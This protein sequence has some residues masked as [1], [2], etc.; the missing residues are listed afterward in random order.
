MQTHKNRWLSYKTSIFTRMSQLSLDHQAINLSQG[1]PN[2]DGPQSIKEAA[3]KAIKDGLNQYAPSPGVLELREKIAEYR[4]S[5]SR[6]SYNPQDEVTVFSGATEALWAALLGLCEHGDEVISFAPFYDSYRPAIEAAGAKLK[7]VC[8]KAPNFSFDPDELKKQIT[9][10]TKMIILNHPHNPTGRVFTHRELEIIADLA[11]TY[12]LLVIADEVYE[13]LVYA[14]HIYHYFSTLPGMRERTIAISSTAKTFSFTGWKI[15]FAFASP[16]ISAIL[17]SV[18]QFTVFCSA[19]PL[20][21][22][23][24]EAFKL[25]SNYFEAFKEEYLLRRAHLEKILL[26][27]GQKPSIPQGTYFML[28]D[29]SK[30]SDKN[31]VDFAIWQTTHAKVSCIPISEFYLEPDKFT[32]QKIVRYAFCKD[33]ETLQKAGYLLEEFYKFGT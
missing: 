1:F 21:Y 19:T 11:L 15:G 24:I 32:Q 20:Q 28:A 3:C 5:K 7:Q 27:C 26:K 18:H 16:S 10:Q 9:S 4:Y 2:F 22:G 12:D 25:G 30:C 31:D 33:V 17:R 13:E 29:Y 14:P 23:M 6:I 8:L